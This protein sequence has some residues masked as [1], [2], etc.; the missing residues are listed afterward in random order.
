MMFTTKII[1]TI[2]IY[3]KLAIVTLKG[4]KIPHPN[5]FSIRDEY[6]WLILL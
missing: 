1:G 5:V 3:Q 6:V 4:H 2:S